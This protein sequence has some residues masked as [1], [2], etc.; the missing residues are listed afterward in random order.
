MITQNK[1]QKRMIL[2]DC[3]EDSQDH[4]M[5]CNKGDKERFVEEMKCILGLEGYETERQKMR[6]SNT[7]H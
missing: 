7:S 4:N 2:I 3:F 6:E 1:T 5:I